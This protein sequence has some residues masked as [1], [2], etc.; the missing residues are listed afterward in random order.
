MVDEFCRFRNK[1]CLGVKPTSLQIVFLCYY[2]QLLIAVDL[3]PL[4]CKCYEFSA[5]VFPLGFWGNSN[6]AYLRIIVLLL[7]GYEALY[8]VVLLINS[9]YVG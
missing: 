1:P 9:G 5:D 4:F 2:F 3:G 6:Q 8:F 7:Y